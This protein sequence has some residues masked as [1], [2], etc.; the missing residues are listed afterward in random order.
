MGPIAAIPVRALPVI[1]P[2]M[3]Q[4]TTDTIPRPPFTLPT[5]ML[6]KSRR[7][8][9]IPLSLINPPMKIKNGTDKRTGLIIC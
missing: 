4:V 9:A 3:P 8:L 2:I 6:T 7:C 1:A 5:K